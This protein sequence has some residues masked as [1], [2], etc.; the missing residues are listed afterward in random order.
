MW[1]KLHGSFIMA[2]GL[3]QH[4][5]C[6]SAGF[7][8][9]MANARTRQPLPDDT[10]VIGLLVITLKLGKGFLG[11]FCWNIGLELICPREKK[12]NERLLV[13]RYDGQDIKAN[14]FGKAGFI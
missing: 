9:A 7:S 8:D 2:H 1:S 11:C 4:V 5:I 6:G 10:R 12:R 3:P 14:T 13:V